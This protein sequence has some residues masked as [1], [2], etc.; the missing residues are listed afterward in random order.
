MEGIYLQDPRPIKNIPQDGCRTWFRSPIFFCAFVRQLDPVVRPLISR[1]RGPSLDRVTR[2]DRRL[3]AGQEPV[4]V[5]AT[6][7]DQAD[8]TRVRPVE[9][10]ESGNRRIQLGLPAPKRVVSA[11]LTAQRLSVDVR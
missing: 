6:V 3:I 1:M 2:T 4:D 5:S 9:V 10:K 11:N 8:T 7:A